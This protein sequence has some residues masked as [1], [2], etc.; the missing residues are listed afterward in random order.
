MY[1][2]SDGQLVLSA[3][4]LTSHLGCGHLTQLRL[5]EVRGERTRARRD[6]SP[7]AAVVRDRGLVHEQAQLKRLAEACGGYADLTHD[8]ELTAD[9]RRQWPPTRAWLEAGRAKTAAAMRAGE[10]LLFQ[11][12]LFDGGWQGIADFLRRVDLADARSDRERAAIEQ[13]SLGGYAYE[14]LDSKLSKEV[15]PYVVHQLALYSRMVRSIR[16]A[17]L[18]VRGAAPARRGAV[19]AHRARAH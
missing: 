6:A 14:V 8:P 4:D 2:L 15:R 17:P 19:R 7:H 11:A 1:R 16:R 5:G 12:Q 18:R 3:S 10:Q 9:G 13:S